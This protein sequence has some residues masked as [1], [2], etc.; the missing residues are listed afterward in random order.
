MGERLRTILPSILSVLLALAVCWCFIALTRDA[1]IASEA[2]LQMLRGGI[3]DW[4]AYLDGGRVTLLTRP[5]GEAA[6]KASLLLLTGLSVTVAFKVGLFNIGAQGQMLMGAL[7]AAV[8]GAQVELPTVLHVIAALLGAAV[9]GGL[10]ALIAAWLKLARGVHEVI[11]TIMLNWVAVSLVDNWLVVGPLRAG[12][13]TTL[14][15]TGTAEIHATA[16]LPR[17]LGDLSRLHLGFPLALAVALGL[18]VWLARLR[19]GFETRAVGLGPEA[20]R[21]AGIPVTRRTAEAMGL[22][23]ALA[24]LAG[25]VLVLGTEFRYPGTLGAPYG[26]DGIAIS[27]IGGNHPLGVTLSALFFGVLRAGGTRMQLLGV[28]KTYPELIQGLAL[29]FVAGR[30]VW[31]TLLSARKRPPEAPAEPQPVPE[32]APQP[33]QRPEVPRV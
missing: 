17:L 20:A 11:S 8:V 16:H 18:W 27:L 32:A 1:R 10:W 25:A 23:G 33:A 30:Q 5:W 26:F 31:L 3:G 7:A 6:I 13:G 19:T 15:T 9:A 14:N 24:G 28:H 12:A 4:G 29:L 22:A 2:Y 21:A